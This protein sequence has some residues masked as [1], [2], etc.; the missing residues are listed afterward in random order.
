MGEETIAQFLDAL[1]SGAPVPGGGAAAALEAAIGAALVAMVCNLTIGR[2]KYRDYEAIMTEARAAAEQLRAQALALAAEDS[3]SYSA[4]GA[5]YGLPRTTDEEKAARQTAIQ[6]ALKGATDVPL[7]TVVLAAG[8]IDL[9]A[10]VVDGANV[11][12]ISDVGVGALSA[13]TAL[14]GA[15]LNVKINLA[16]IKDEEFKATT[17]ARMNEYLQRAR[18]LVDEVTGKVEASISR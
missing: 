1:A 15:A 12:A 4:V 6:N 5:T 18:P 11:N 8:I 2:E 7:R 3:A 14:E 9:C 13:R 10:R 16:L 17:A